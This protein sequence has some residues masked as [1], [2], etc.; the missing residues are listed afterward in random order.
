MNNYFEFLRLPKDKAKLLVG[1]V[2]KFD[3]QSL[4]M[5]IELDER[6]SYNLSTKYSVLIV[7]LVR[8]PS[9]PETVL[10]HVPGM[11]D[12]SFKAFFTGSRLS[13]LRKTMFDWVMKRGCENISCH[14]LEKLCRSL[15]AGE[16][17]WN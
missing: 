7:G 6:C 4:Y 3:N 8:D 1:L 5:V 14:E 15:G 9:K 2:G 10:V 16:I 17:D 11:D 12:F 13:E